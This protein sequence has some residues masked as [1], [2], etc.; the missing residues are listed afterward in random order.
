VKC[1]VIDVEL[2]YRAQKIST[3]NYQ[4]GIIN[5]E[6]SAWNYQRGIFNVEFSTWNFQR[7]IF[8][9]ATVATSDVGDISVNQ[10]TSVKPPEGAFTT[11]GYI[12]PGRLDDEPD[13]TTSSTS[14]VEVVRRRK[15]VVKQSGAVLTLFTKRK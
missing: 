5:V 10:V 7:G 11:R 3:W 9:V 12:V 8:N 6:L 4:R 1:G 2:Q 13:T 14:W 15:P